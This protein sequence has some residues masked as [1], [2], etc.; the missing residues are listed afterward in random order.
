MHGRAVAPKA[1]L[2]VSA[3]PVREGMEGSMSASMDRVIAFSVLD[4]GRVITRNP[5]IPDSS[6]TCIGRAFLDINGSSNTTNSGNNSFLISA[7]L[8]PSDYT[9]RYREPPN[10]SVTALSQR[11]VLLTVVCSMQ[12]VPPDPIAEDIRITV[13]SWLPNGSPARDIAYHWR[14]RVPL[15]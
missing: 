13:Y 5:Y 2:P 10:V 14:C 3:Q 1:K 6:N 9:P 11:P 12:V 7:F 4:S 15:A 8:C